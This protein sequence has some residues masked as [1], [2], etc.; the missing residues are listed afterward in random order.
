MNVPMMSNF[1]MRG[2]I[3]AD[4]CDIKGKPHGLLVWQDRPDENSIP[5]AGVW[6][7]LLEQQLAF[8]P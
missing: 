4:L 2:V 6:F 7:A 3:T 5:G 1:M 8:M